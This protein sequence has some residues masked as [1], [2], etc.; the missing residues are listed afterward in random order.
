MNSYSATT[1]PPIVIICVHNTDK[2][3][4]IQFLFK[5]FSGRLYFCKQVWLND[6][7]FQDITPP[8]FPGLTGDHFILATMIGKIYT[9][10][11]MTDINA[12]YPNFEF[13][14][15]HT[16]LYN[17]HLDRVEAYLGLLT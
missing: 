7:T 2:D 15:H 14:Y 13:E 5:K 8:K 9:D 11:I 1:I 12:K 6:E 10:K 16:D 17:Y 3:L 4:R